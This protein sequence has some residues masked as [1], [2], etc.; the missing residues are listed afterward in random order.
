MD[1]V[2]EFNKSVEA[3]DLDLVRDAIHQDSELIH[4]FTLQTREWGEEMWLPLHRAAYHGHADIVELLLKHGARPDSRTRF[5]T[6]FHARCSAMH[7]AA[8]GG[9]EDILQMLIDAGGDPNVLNTQNAAPLH[10]AC[11]YG[12]A[13]AV[14]TL[15]R[16]RAQ[17][18]LRDQDDRTPLHLAVL[19]DHAEVSGGDPTAVVPLLLEHD[20]NVDATCPKEPAS[21]T[22]LHRCVTLGMDRYEC[23]VALVKANAKTDLRDPVREKTALDLAGDALAQGD[24]VMQP[25]VDL[26]SK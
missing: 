22:P 12:R 18:E 21:Y 11:R 7:F 15:L 23:A 26:L 2:V 20:A 8:A 6:P 25:Y 5:R 17:I 9:Y 4:T 24:T 14:A 10:W 19:G 1:R 3:G 16:H 13:R